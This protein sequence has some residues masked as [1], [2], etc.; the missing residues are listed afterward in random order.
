[1]MDCGDVMQDRDKY[2]SGDFRFRK[3]YSKNPRKMCIPSASPTT[4]KI[5]FPLGPHTRGTFLARVSRAQKMLKGHLPRVIY[6]Q[7]YWYKKMDTHL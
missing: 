7:V 4:L 3:G 1:M 5:D 6:H 2:I